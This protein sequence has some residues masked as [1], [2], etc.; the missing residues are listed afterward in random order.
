MRQ[1]LSSLD[2]VGLLKDTC[3]VFGYFFAATDEAGEKVDMP[4]IFG[5][6]KI[7][8]IKKRSEWP[9]DK[10]ATTTFDCEE[11]ERPTELSC[12]APAT[13]LGGIW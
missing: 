10:R 3:V 4:K 8:V 12:T 11:C 2:V 1:H 13:D 6:R 9:I 7:Q 5:Q